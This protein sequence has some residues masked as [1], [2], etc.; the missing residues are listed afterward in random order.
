MAEFERTSRPS[1]MVKNKISAVKWK[2]TS[3]T[4]TQQMEPYSNDKGKSKALGEPLGA[5]QKKN[6]CG[7]KGKGK[8]WVHEIVSSA[9]I[10]HDCH[11]TSLAVCTPLYTLVTVHISPLFHFAYICWLLFGYD[12]TLSC[13]Q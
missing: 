10:P 12:L 5:P 6:R 4:F 13:S 3:P 11:G 8:A 7:G 1:T 9:L 2:G